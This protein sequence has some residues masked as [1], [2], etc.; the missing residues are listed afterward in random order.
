AHLLT[1]SRAKAALTKALEDASGRLRLIVAGRYQPVTGLAHLQA[2]GHLIELRTD[3]LAFDAGEVMKL[4]E[5]HDVRLSDDA[6]SALSGRTGGWATAVALAMPWLARSADTS[7]AVNSF[8]GDDS[9]VA[10]FLITEVLAG[11]DEP[12]RSVMTKAAVCAYVPVDL[13]VRL[14]GHDDAGTLLHQVAVS[15]ALI[16]EDAHGF[17]FHP[18]LLAFLQAESRRLSRVDAAAHH[19]LAAEWFVLHEQ[20]VEALKQAMNATDDVL[21]R[22]LEELGLELTLVGQNTLIASAL[23]RFAVDDT[24]P[25]AV[26]VLRLLLDAPSF[27]DPR[28]AHHLLALADR[29]VATTPERADAWTVA[30]DALRCFIAVRD[31]RSFAGAS[32]LSDDRAM[33]R[34]ESNLGL[35]LLCA[36]AEGWLFARIGETAR[37]QAALRDVR[38][39]AHR[40]GLDWLLLVASELEINVLGDLGRWDEAVVIEDRL[41]D[42]AGRFSRTPSDRMRRRVELVAATRAYLMCRDTDADSLQRLAA[43]D[44]LGLDPELSVTARV[45]ELLPSLDTDQ[46]PRRALD[47]VERM[48]REAGVYVPR[49]LALAAPRLI[50][51]RVMLDGRARARETAEL[52]VGILGADSVEGSI[53]RFLLSVPVR[54]TEP[55][56]RQLERAA[57]GGHAWHPASFVSAWLWLARFAE[58]GGRIA[59]ADALTLRALEAAD[60]YRLVRPF[61]SPASDGLGLLTERLGRF[62]HHELQARRIV[63]CAP[64]AVSATSA[65]QMIDSLTPKEREILVELPVHQSVAEIARRHSLSV[66]TVKT[67]LRNIYQKLGV[68]DRSEAVGTAQRLGLI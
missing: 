47:E 5:R 54:S 50:A 27:S 68:T 48:M 6:A 62:G 10:D 4:A 12:T 46:N 3:D 39:A 8:N 16:D 17:R 53:A 11:F 15:N 49:T 9:A 24:A 21:A 38:V 60:R 61:L 41:V 55:V 42:V 20:P 45:L 32:T 29:V 65:T 52:V 19:A 33:S 18:V 7:A 14:S 57:S 40:A 64:E 36:T 23:A 30:L 66:N 1:S 2:A 28:R 31:R 44:S 13:A 26:L 43:S 37:A 56:V 35:D 59:E 63:D 67:H 25:L 34:R 51:I 22:M 58:D